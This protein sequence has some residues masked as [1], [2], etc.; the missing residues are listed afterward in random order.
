MSKNYGFTVGFAHK[1]ANFVYGELME[2]CSVKVLKRTD[3]AI[4]VG[5]YGV[6]FGGVDLDGE[7]FTQDTDFMPDLVPIKSVFYDHAS[8]EKVRNI[9]GKASEK[10]DDAGIWVEAQLDRSKKYIDE[11]MELIEKGILGW[12]SGSAGHLNIRDGK[13]IKRWAVVEY[14]LTPTP[15]EP[16][17]L[18]VERIKALAEANPNLKALL[19]EEPGDGSSAGVTVTIAD[20]TQVINT[21][22]KSMDAKEVQTAIDD[23]LKK[24]REE[25]EAKAAAE[26]AEQDK[27]DAA[28]A[29]AK[30]AWKKEQPPIKEPGVDV[31]KDETDRKGKNPYK[32]FGD[33]LKDVVTAE[34]GGGIAKELKAI[35]ATGLNEGIPSQ[36]G[37]LVQQDFSSELLKRTYEMGALASRI[38]MIPIS[39]NANG[40]KINAINETSR[41]STRW[42]GIV[43]YWLAEAGSKTASKPEF[44]QIDLDLKKVIG[45]CYATDELLQD[46]TALES[47]IREG[48]NEEIEFQVEDKIYNGLGAGVPL[49]IMASG[50]LVSVTKETGQAADTIVAENITKM[51]ARM[52]GKS[53][54]NAVWYINQDVEPELQ[55]MDLPVGTGGLPVYLPPGGL[56]DSPYSRLMGRPVI[57]VE[58]AATLGDTGDIMLA[59]MSQ[60][61]GIDKGGVQSAS[62]IHVN[63]TYD[64]TVFRFVYRFDGQPSWNSALTPY[65]GTDTLSPFVVLNERT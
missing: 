43:G 11:I 5:G 59:D 47:V 1:A 64:E 28:V 7:T 23:A 10:V 16:R 14:S 65:K 2:D 22:V 63:F 50:C 32:S 13:A 61:I 3:E 39:G 24:D 45:L 30:T 33:F 34:T 29:E 42:G 51:W 60:Y 31:T 19:P 48:F 49:G 53:R 55:N 44:R 27:I 21:G 46:A 20:A 18:G 25:R 62:S 38:R 37:F 56:S 15:A 4:T 35:K 12:S 52:W 6:I 58:Y 41:A 40:L 57:P 26:K 17:T 36:G 9:L 8:Q 54:A